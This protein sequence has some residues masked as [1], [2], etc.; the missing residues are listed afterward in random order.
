MSVSDARGEVR[1]R[2]LAGIWWLVVGA[3]I[4]FGIVGLLTVG[5]P[6]LV[7]GLV[8][9]VAGAVM[10]QTRNRSAF[11]AVA[12]ASAAP[13]PWRGSTKAV[14]APCAKQAGTRLPAWSSGAPG[15][16]SWQRSCSSP[17]ALSWPHARTRSAPIETR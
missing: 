14:L 12:G 8:M 1:G 4:G 3:A 15:L 2:S 17:S 10:P 5:A 13:S 11:M 6:F 16:S 9:A 7:L